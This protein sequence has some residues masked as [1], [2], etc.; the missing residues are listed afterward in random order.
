MTS[1]WRLLGGRVEARAAKEGETKGRIPLELLL[2]D[3]GWDRTA[4]SS[5]AE[6]DR[7]PDNTAAAPRQSQTGE[8][9]MRGRQ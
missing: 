7:L 2:E 4:L 5:D 8:K 9:V 1:R 6:H 3:S